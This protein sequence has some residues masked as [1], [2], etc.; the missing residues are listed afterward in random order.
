MSI[1]TVHHRSL[2]ALFVGAASIVALSLAPSITRTAGADPVRWDVPREGALP[3]S[4]RSFVITDPNNAVVMVEPMG[5][6]ALAGHVQFRAGFAV[7]RAQRGSGCRSQWLEIEE[8]AWVCGDRGEL[9][10]NAPSAPNPIAATEEALPWPYAF[11]GRDDV[12]AYKTEA[13]ALSLSESPAD[14]E[15]WEA[16]WGFAVDSLSGAGDAR[17]LRTRSGFFVRRRDA[18]RANPTSFEGGAFRQLE[19][20]DRGI[21]F[22]WV[23]LGATRVYAGPSETGPSE[24]LLRLSPIRVF[25]VRGSG[26]RPMARI[27][28]DRWARADHLRWIAPEPPPSRVD[29]ARRERWIDVDVATQTLIAYEG[30]EPVYATMVSTGGERSPTQPGVFRIWG[31]YIAHTMDNT[32]S[33]HLPNHFRLGD[34]PYVQFF[35]DDR[36]LHGVYWHDQFGTP[37]SHGCVNLSPRDARWLF[38]FAAGQLRPGWISRAMADGEGTIVRVRGRFRHR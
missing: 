35:D 36:G 16:N 6:G 21:P 29:L 22:G 11:T 4:A 30:A 13:A 34:V 24:P 2:A 15:L 14:F 9:S 26:R 28:Q 31:R 25:E 20:A 8:R 5:T 18:Y 10:A 12:R 7:R 27:G 17:V 38:R 19:G 23:S 33:A 37:R 32:E 3:A 1:R